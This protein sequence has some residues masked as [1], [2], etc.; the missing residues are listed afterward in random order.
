M[1]STLGVL[2]ALG[3]GVD[4]GNESLIGELQKQILCFGSFFYHLCDVLLAVYGAASIV[5]TKETGSYKYLFYLFI[6][7]TVVAWGLAFIG[8]RIALLW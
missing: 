6:F 8:Y 1:V 7:T 5:F 4:E 3:A 2:Y